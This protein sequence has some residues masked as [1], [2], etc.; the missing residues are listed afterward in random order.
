MNKKTLTA[1]AAASTLCAAALPAGADIP[2]LV[3]YQGRLLLGGE[4]VNSNAMP[5]TISIYSHPTIGA[6]LY[7]EDDVVNVIDGLFATTIGDNSNGSGSESTLTAALQAAGAGAWLAVKVAGGPALTPRERIT[8]APY[9]LVTEGAA[10]EIDPV[11]TNALATG[12]TVGGPVHLPEDGLT[13][14]T[15]QLVVAGGEVGIGTALP[16]QPLDVRGDAN[17]GGGL[18]DFDGFAEVLGISAK[19]QTWYMG[20]VNA[21]TGNDSGFFIASASAGNDQFFIQRDSKTGIGTDTPR[22]QLEVR[23]LNSRIRIANTDQTKGGV[24]ITDEDTPGQRFARV[25]FDCDDAHDADLYFYVSSNYPVMTLT[26]GQRVGI[27]TSSPDKELDVTGDVTVGGGDEA[28]GDVEQIEIRALNQTWHMG[29]ENQ[30][31]LTHA[32]FFIGKQDTPDGTFHI[33]QNGNI[34]LG[35]TSPGHALTIQGNSPNIEIR[36]DEETISGIIFRDA[37]VP[38]DQFAKAV[39]NAG[40]GALLFFVNDSSEVAFMI[41]DAV[42]TEPRVG[43]GTTDPDDQLTIDG[44]SPRV[45]I[46]NSEEDEAGIIMVDKQ[47]AH[48]QYAKLVYDAGSEKFNVYVNDIGESALTVTDAPGEMPRLGV[49]TYSPSEQL[50]IDGLSPNMLLQNAEETES[51]VLFADKNSPDEE[52]A[53]ILYDAGSTDMKILVNDSNRPAL[54]I[55]DATNKSTE[56]GINT[57]DPQAELHVCGGKGSALLY[58]EADIDNSG[59]GNQPSIL[60]SQDGGAVEAMIGFDGGATEGNSLKFRTGYSSADMIFYTGSDLVTDQTEQMRVSHNGR[61]IVSVLEITGGADLAESFDITAENSRASP[62]PGTVVCI[63]AERPGAL[64]ASTQPYDRRVAGV[65]SG[66]GGVKPGMVMG[67]HDSAADGSCPVALTGR[68]YCRADAGYGRITPGDLLTTS[69]TPGHAMRVDDHDRANGAV[70]G[71]AMT[72]LDE[73]TGLV[74][75]LVG[76]Q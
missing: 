31:G 7:Q 9:A 69:A 4:L 63:D 32:D 55:R 39:Y 29:V 23:G 66:A 3:S 38:A 72:S 10:D 61:V 60:M 5:V 53:R 24:V 17:I 18:A 14:G 26:S 67:Q 16:S 42:G 15:D 73:G 34:G 47:N 56:V 8:A 59:E 70:L 13:V 62:D 2:G 33:N 20:V 64:V 28:D 68:V 71:K 41:E 57:D 51:G 1:L 52:F 25:L 35:T 12:F 22:E 27:L 19:E 36:N 30:T 45:R 49:G 11:W 75:V 65:I 6:P 50:T 54:F 43:I 74:L 40:T 76:L 37:D 58:L 48:D 21:D 46:Q 44:G